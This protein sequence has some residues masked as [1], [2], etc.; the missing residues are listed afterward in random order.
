M[1][2]NHETRA[3]R[4]WNWAVKFIGAGTFVGAALSD[5]LIE[6][7]TPTF[8]IAFF[9]LLLM[10]LPMADV[11]VILRNWRRTNDKEST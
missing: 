8:F 6:G 2:D 7:S 10:V 3:D 9:G 5:F 1:S 4:V 11:R